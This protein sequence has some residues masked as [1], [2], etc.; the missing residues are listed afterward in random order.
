MWFWCLPHLKD[1]EAGANIA[2]AAFSQSSQKVFVHPG[3][4]F[5]LRDRV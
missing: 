4:V 2:A 1:V 3:N 5:E